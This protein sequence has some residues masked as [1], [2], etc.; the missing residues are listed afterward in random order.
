[1]LPPQTFTPA[2]PDFAERVR[3]SFARQRVMT[4]IG[5]TLTSVAPGEVVIELPFRE[6]L[7]QQHGFLHAGIVAAIVDSACGF[8]A[9]TLMPRDAA[10]LTA[11]YKVNFLAPAAGRRFVAYGRVTKAG[12]TLTVTAGDVVAETDAGPKAVA[13]MLATVMTVSGRDIA[14]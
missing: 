10:V 7:T 12:R 3:A 8:A 4:T 1:M 14:G 6:D 11:E 9:F 13:T 2:D 5:A